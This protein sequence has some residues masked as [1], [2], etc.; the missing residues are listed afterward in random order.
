MRTRKQTAA[1]GLLGFNPSASW[2][3]LG[4]S[5][6]LWYAGE[7]CANDAQ[8]LRND[9]NVGSC[10]PTKHPEGLTL[11][12]DHTGCAL[13]QVVRDV[14]KISNGLGKLRELM[15]IECNIARMASAIQKQSLA[16]V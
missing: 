8:Q 2:V 16:T 11:R 6:R 5:L 7:D 10:E 4:R 3:E 13:G 14:A 9:R 15:F 12:S 1:Q